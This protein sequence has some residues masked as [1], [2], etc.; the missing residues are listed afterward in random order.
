[1]FAVIILSIFGG[2]GL[3]AFSEMILIG[4]IVGT[5]SSIFISSPI[6]LLYSRNKNLRKEVMDTELAGETAAKA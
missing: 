6:V 5:Y 2:S 1:V 3:R 4:L